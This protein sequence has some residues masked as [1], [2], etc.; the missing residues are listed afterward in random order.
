MLNC[1]GF[2]PHPRPLSQ[3]GREE[4]GF[5]W[6]LKFVLTESAEQPPNLKKFRP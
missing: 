2:D 5:L 3:D 1:L 4:S 6:K